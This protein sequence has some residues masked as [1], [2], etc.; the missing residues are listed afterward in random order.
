MKYRSERENCSARLSADARIHKHLAF[1]MIGCLSRGILQARTIT[2]SGG[3]RG[4]EQ[5]DIYSAARITE[6]NTRA[7]LQI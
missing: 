5:T 1:T 7:Q 6:N 2:V 3:Y 4:N